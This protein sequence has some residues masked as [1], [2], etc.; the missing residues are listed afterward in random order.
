MNTHKDE[1]I[2]FGGEKKKTGLFWNQGAEVP[3]FRAGK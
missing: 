3:L 2:F 1:N